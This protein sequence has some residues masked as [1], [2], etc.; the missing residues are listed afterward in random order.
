MQ[1]S[2]RDHARMPVKKELEGSRPNPAGFAKSEEYSAANPEQLNSHFTLR[3]TYP[4]VAFMY[5]LMKY[6]RW[7][8]YQANLFN[9]ENGS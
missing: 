8:N 9:A 1:A 3:H 6:N 4:C 5:W 2:E 7:G